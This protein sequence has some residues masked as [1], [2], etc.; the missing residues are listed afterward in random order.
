M[1]EKKKKSQINN[2]NFPPEDT[3]KEEQNNPKQ[4]EGRKE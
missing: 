2:P 3:R 1:L 4:A